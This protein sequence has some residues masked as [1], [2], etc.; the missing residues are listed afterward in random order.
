MI[1]P[2]ADI[3]ELVIESAKI[4]SAIQRASVIEDAAQIIGRRKRT[5]ISPVKAPPPAT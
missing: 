1:A 2:P 4:S 5:A 3:R